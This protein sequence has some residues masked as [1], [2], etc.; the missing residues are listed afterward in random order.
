MRLSAYDDAREFGQPN[1]IFKKEFFMKV[2]IIGNIEALQN[3]DS[4]I[5]DLLNFHP[6]P[7]I[8]SNNVRK[9]IGRIEIQ[10]QRRY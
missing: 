6:K 8:R 1:K 2:K 4:N 10:Q 3:A 5:G 7:R 9:N